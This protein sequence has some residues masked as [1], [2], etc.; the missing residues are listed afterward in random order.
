MFNSYQSKCKSMGFQNSGVKN[1]Y[2]SSNNLLF[3]NRFSNR[4]ICPSQ[5]QLKSLDFTRVTIVDS[6][7][8][9][10][11]KKLYQAKI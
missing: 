7:K 11:K 3:K 2:K 6:V 10:L 4:N 9:F 8:I 5:I 1:K